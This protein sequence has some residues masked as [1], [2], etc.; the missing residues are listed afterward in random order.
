MK[1]PNRIIRIATL[2]LAML[3]GLGAVVAQPALPIEYRHLDGD[4]AWLN[5][6]SQ[7]GVPISQEVDNPPGSNGDQPTGNESTG[8][9]TPPTSGQFRGFLSSGSAAPPLDYA[10][11][12]AVDKPR[13]PVSD[14]Y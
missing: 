6:Q 14:R 9:F 11:P 4:R 7:G 13:G 2:G 8:V 5:Y 12:T 3:A 1:R 10:P